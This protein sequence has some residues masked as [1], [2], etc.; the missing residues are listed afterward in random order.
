MD[1]QREWTK[2][3]VQGELGQRKGQTADRSGADRAMMFGRGWIAR[4]L[5]VDRAMMIDRGWIA[6]EVVRRQID[7]RWITGQI[8]RR[9][10]DQGA[11]A[12]GQIGELRMGKSVIY[13]WSWGRGKTTDL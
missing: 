5:R 11:I 9:Q 13:N 8:V 4:W 12:Q 10:V 6:G 2:L 3:R 1:A 7:P